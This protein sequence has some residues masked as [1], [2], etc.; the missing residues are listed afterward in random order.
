MGPIN[1]NLQPT[2]IGK[3]Q[4]LSELRSKAQFSGPVL[5]FLERFA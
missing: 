4:P 2:E 3:P 5:R 1:T